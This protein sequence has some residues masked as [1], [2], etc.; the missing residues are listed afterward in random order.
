LKKFFI[1][2]ACLHPDLIPNEKV[3][4]APIPFDAQHP[5]PGFRYRAVID[6]L[7][8]VVVSPGA[9]PTPPGSDFFQSGGAAD[10]SASIGLGRGLVV[11]VSAFRWGHPLRVLQ[12][13]LRCLWCRPLDGTGGLGPPVW[14]PGGSSAA[15]AAPPLL[16]GMG[17][18]GHPPVGGWLQQL[19]GL[20][21]GR[22]CRSRRFRRVVGG[23]W[24][25]PGRDPFVC[26]A[27]LPLAPSRWRFAPGAE[28][29]RLCRFVLPV[30]L[31]LQ[32]RLLLRAGRALQEWTYRSSPRVWGL[33]RW[34]VRRGRHPLCL[35]LLSR[36]LRSSRSS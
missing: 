6:I 9:P 14:R 17:T 4:W 29:S 5:Q 11:F 35:Y 23:G 7:E 15:P 34:S 28:R 33:S 1:T 25:G 36:P 24:A 21:V 19:A 20:L 8:V 16:S 31:G 26:W 32:G 2:V 30:M 22:R 27:G 10:T 18:A 13:W 12:G 3:M